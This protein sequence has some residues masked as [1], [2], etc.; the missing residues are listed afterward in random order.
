[1]TSTP[2][3][4]SKPTPQ[5]SLFSIAIPNPSFDAEE[6][7]VLSGICGGHCNNSGD[8]EAFPNAK[9]SL[10]AYIQVYTYT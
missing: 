8:S 3:M 2:T 5:L 6:S 4:P 9:T 7:P 1:M 10:H